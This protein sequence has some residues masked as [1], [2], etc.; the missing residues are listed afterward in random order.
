VLVVLALLV[1]ARSAAASCNQIPGAASAFRGT[2]GVVDRPFAT[3]GD[4]VELRVSPACDP[5]TPGFSSDAADHVV[6]VVFKPPEG[7]RNV[8]ILAH[9]CLA[10]EGERQACAARSGVASA[11]CREFDGAAETSAVRVI[12]QEGQRRLRVGFPDT[13]DLLGGADDDRTLTGPAALAVS[14]ADAPIPCAL[15]EE[16]CA[17]LDGVLVCVDELFAVNGS[18]DRTPHATFSHFTA[19]PPP[20]DYQALC[21]DPQPPCTGA[22][23]ELRLTVDAAGNLLMPMDWAGVLLRPGVPI[24]RLVRG[25]SAVEAFPGS[26]QPIRLPDRNVLSSFSPQGNSLPPI[27]EPQLDPSGPDTLTL[28]GSVDARETVL[29]IARFGATDRACSGGANSG[30]PC[31]QADDC[32]GAECQPGDPLFDFNGRLAD[33]V[34]PIVLAPKDFRLE[35]QEPVALDA[36]LGT[37]ELFAFV[38]PE[39]IGE[40]ETGGDVARNTARKDLNG[41]GDTLDDVLVLMNRHTGV[42]EPTGRENASG[43]AATRIRRPPFSFPAVSA[44]G[45]LVAFLESEAAEGHRDSSQDGDVSD[46]ILRVFR[47]ADDGPVTEVTAGMD[48]AVDAAPL[49]GEQSLIVSDGLVFFRRSEAAASPR[50]TEM[51]SVASDGSQSYDTAGAIAFRPAL[52]GNG[53]RVAF[54]SRADDLLV[55]PLKD[56]NFVADVFVRDRRKGVTRRV[57][58]PNDGRQ[59]SAPSGASSVSPDGRFVAFHSDAD[60]TNGASATRDVFLHDLDTGQTALLEIRRREPVLAMGAG[61][62][63]VLSNDSNA[64]AF[65]HQGSSSRLIGSRVFQLSLNTNGEVAVFDSSAQSAPG[66]TNGVTDVFAHDL[67]TGETRLVSVAGSGQAGDQSSRNPSVSGDGRFVAFQSDADNL[68]AGDTNSA[69]DV[70]VHDRTT[71]A[72]ERVSLASDG[73][74]GDRASLLPQRSTRV[75]SSD[76]RFVA[77]ESFATNLVPDDTNGAAD[78]FVHD[79][80]TGITERVS[81]ASDGTPGNHTTYGFPL[82][83]SGDGLVVAFDSD[84]D[85]LVANDDNNARD[86]FV[87]A[88]ST[89]DVGAVDLTGDGDLNDTVLQV[90]DTASHQLTDLGP[91]DIVAVSGRSAAFLRPES[92]VNPITRTS[93]D[94]PVD[95]PQPILGPPADPTVSSVIVQASGRITDVDVVGL[96][97][98]HDYVGDLVIRLRSPQGTEVTLSSRRGFD[99]KGYLATTFDDEAP[100]P[101]GGGVAPF[102]GAFM[103]DERLSSFN[104]E[105]PIGE[106]TLT[107]DDLVPVDGGVLSSWGL[108]IEVEHAEDLN[109]DLD[110]DD[111]VVQL[112]SGGAT[113]ENL[114]RAA[115]ELSISDDWIGALVSE[116]MQG[117]TDLNGDADANDDVL[118]IYDRVAGVWI[119]TGQP[120]DTVKVAGSLVA[121]IRPERDQ[122]PTGEDLTGDGDTG[123]RVLGLFDAASRK[124]IPVTDDA[125]YMQAAEEFVMGPPLCLGGSRDGQECAASGD[126]P[127][128]GWCGPALVAFRTSESAQG[129]NLIGSPEHDVDVLQVYDVRA[130]R[131]LNTGEAVIPCRFEACNARFPYQVRSGTVTFL[132]LETDQD[133]DLNNDGDRSDLILQTFNA[134]LALDALSVTGTQLARTLR[135]GA[136]VFPGPVTTLGSVGA[137]VCSDSGHPCLQDGDCTPGTCFIPPGGCLKD[138]AVS[139]QPSDDPLA[140]PPCGSGEFCGK[141]PGLNGTFHCIADVGS[142]RS[143]ASCE[144][145]VE[146]QQGGCRCANAG[147]KFL[148]LPP[149]L[150]GGPG[151]VQVF[152]TPEAGLCVEDTEMGCNAQQPCEGRLLCSDAGVCQRAG[153]PCRNDGDC[154]SGAVC[155][156]ELVI[157]G[158]SDSD[159]DEI[160]D[161]FD[162]CPEVANVGQADTDLDGI[163]DACQGAPPTPTG[164]VLPAATSTPTRTE[165]ATA[166]A[167][168]TSTPTTSPTVTPMA[169]PTAT[170]RAT[171]T[172][173]ATGIATRT[174]GAT[175]TP[176]VCVGDCGS[177][178]TVTVNELIVGVNIALGGLALESCPAF[179]CNGSGELTIDCLVRAVDASLNGCF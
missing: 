36:L 134:R 88:P 7:E 132:T 151:G 82:A 85:N 24:A 86:L 140:P 81:V 80:L 102:S 52:D 68:V 28:F 55:E 90:L 4:V 17:N 150:A 15:A 27:F 97:I 116:P 159:D 84:A 22:A 30:L 35:T 139:C 73:T 66:D 63:G 9:D 87:R 158:A 60:L 58:V 128:N 38:V 94:A 168:S 3:P 2:R 145:L 5:A 48:L 125:G 69:T 19:L 165:P 93:S 147:Q 77:F 91:A 25:S 37:E 42:L 118:A 100:R 152:V 108:E 112:Y 31:V 10:R 70:F 171:R 136:A 29:R 155:H 92:A 146:C 96:D 45:S 65:V 21:T 71:G 172:L 115:T 130:R 127:E 51:V 163:G 110:S 144:A 98:A 67:T 32:P 123:D 89:D 101:I 61:I 56:A 106:W 129:R 120:A 119:D 113:A 78:V 18:C 8:L 57:S 50:R 16:P 95:V 143:D 53:S 64:Q 117:Q 137:G 160:A 75:L 126:C 114:G 20:N 138:L 43:R 131:L 40:R 176:V 6:T 153:E 167:A 124:L 12:E 79:R 47:L 54:E 154:P 46:T 1:D 179:D 74:Q 41:D 141:L 109:G 173:T 83:L 49:V 162:N 11:V 133:D 121:F 33:G 103:P 107:V 76:G 170:P 169:S 14:L 105:N 59:V 23:A 34:G 135:T 99:G 122:G 142:C 161:P 164:S 39:A 175:Y 111:R 44:E 156:R 178:G 62:V 149:P 174:V 104:G 166:T 13:D 148:R 72:T 26:D 157:V 177:D